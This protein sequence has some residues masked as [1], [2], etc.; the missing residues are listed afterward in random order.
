MSIW[1]KRITAD[2]AFWGIVTGFVFNV[3]PSALVYLGL[4]DLP[5]YLDPA[6]IGAGVSIMTI[7]TVSKF[8]HVTRQEAVYRMRLHRT[9]SID[10]DLQ[11][12][13]ITL[14]APALLIVTRAGQRNVPIAGKRVPTR[15]RSGISNRPNQGIYPA[16]GAGLRHGAPSCP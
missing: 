16:Y 3:V 2:A 5:S 7:I 13:K 14:L 11:K 6:V 15:F 8:G 4:I 12:T 1:S 10:Y 9:P